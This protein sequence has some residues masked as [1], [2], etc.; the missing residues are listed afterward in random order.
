MAPALEPK[1]REICSLVTCESQLDVP[2]PRLHLVLLAR[3]M[4]ALVLFIQSL[5]SDSHEKMESLS[6]RPRAIMDRLLNLATRL[7]ITN[8]ELIDSVEGLEC[9]LIQGP[10]QFKCRQYTTELAISS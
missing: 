4:L 1:R 8:N 9:V 3:Y 2:G 7:V 10:Y 6:E 5:H